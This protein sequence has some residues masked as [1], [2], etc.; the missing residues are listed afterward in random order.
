MEGKN[1]ILYLTILPAIF[2]VGFCFT[3]F[4]EAMD[5]DL[6]ITEIMYDPDE[7]ENGQKSDWIEMYNSSDKEIF[8]NKKYLGFI[9]EPEKRDVNGKLTNTCHTFDSDLALKPGEFAI[10][11][12]KKDIIEEIYPNLRSPILDTIVDLSQN[13]DTF[14]ISFDRC[15]SWKIE[16]SYFKEWG[17]Y[18]NNRSLEKIDFTKGNEKENWQESYINGGTPGAKSS[19]KQKY[20]KDVVIS[21]LLPDTSEKEDAGEFIELFN[22]S[23]TD[24]DLTNW[25]LEDNSRTFRFGNSDKKDNLFA[26]CDSSSI[27]RGNSYLVICKERS[28]LLMSNDRE[29]SK[30]TLRDPNGDE[31]DTTSYTGPTK[32]NFAFAL[33][34][35]KFSW[36]S[37]P[38]PGA[39]NII[40]T[41]ESNKTIDEN[42]SSAEKVYLSEIFPH[43]KGDERTGEF[44]E[45]VNRENVPVDLYKW[46]IRNATKTA[47]YIFKDHAIIQPDQYIVIYRSQYKFALN[48]SKGSAYLYNPQG[49]MTSSVSYDESFE[50]VSYNFDGTD[51]H[52]SKFFTPGA[53]NRFD[54][55]PKIRLKKIKSA[56]KN[57]FIKFSV[58]AKDKETKKLKYV[59]DFG[60]GHKSYLKNTSHKYLKTGKYLAKLTVRDESQSVEKDFPI[61]VKKYP[62]PKIEITRAV[63]NP[64]G[65]DSLGEVVTL[66]NIS[67][68]KVSLLNFKIATG[69]QKLV[70]HPIYSDI[71]LNPGEEKIITRVDSKIVLNNKAG[72]IALLYPDG[73]VVDEIQYAKEKIEDDEAY[74]KIDG[75]W[76]WIAANKPKENKKKEENNILADNANEE[77]TDQPVVLGASDEKDALYAN[78]HPGFVPEDAFIFLSQIGF[79]KPASDNINYCSASEP[80]S[81]FAYLL[82]SFF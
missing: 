10:T 47:K 50:N 65:L 19:E 35:G 23:E 67:G 15:K 34:G 70:N 68:K 11:A 3:N 21:E 45:I 52:W 40:T 7:N 72:K 37:T 60:D 46:M 14:K 49:K 6:I 73:K 1:K 2:L 12:D 62:R 5:D 51:W 48:N 25:S 9:D 59:W 75:Q 64:K 32:E 43:P 71:I 81:L 29:G 24:I 39:E 17:G 66:K 76:Q 16:F 41:P 58:K 63:P 55:P 54:S 78:Y 69:S 56:Y 42:L 13:G 74:T 77:T 44:I 53:K 61:L 28:G 18:G 79:I 36:T 38:T 57:I 31:A 22:R 26:Y 4:A 20:S 30:I 82:I 33:D 8:I 27:L 80:S